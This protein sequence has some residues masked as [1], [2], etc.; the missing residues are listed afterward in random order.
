MDTLNPFGTDYLDD[1]SWLD[2]TMPE[3]PALSPEEEAMLVLVQKAAQKLVAEK[4]SQ[5]PSRR[6]KEDPASSPSQKITIRLPKYLLDLLRGKAAQFGM[7][8]QT[9]IKTILQAHP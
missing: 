2:T 1:P 3:M 4:A 7:P 9:Y 5:Q 6:K 8:Y